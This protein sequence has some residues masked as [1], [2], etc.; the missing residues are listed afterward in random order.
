MGEWW[1][2]GGETDLQRRHALPLWRVGAMLRA[3][4]TEYSSVI[5][6]EKERKN[7]I[8]GE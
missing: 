2:F 5:S 3:W 8:K 7:K 6:V 1:G 4:L